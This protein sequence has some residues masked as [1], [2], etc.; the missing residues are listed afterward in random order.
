MVFTDSIASCIIEFG[1]QLNIAPLRVA[2]FDDLSSSRMSSSASSST[3]ETPLRNALEIL[4]F[5]SSYDT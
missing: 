5:G 2:V 3:L 4:S 1:D